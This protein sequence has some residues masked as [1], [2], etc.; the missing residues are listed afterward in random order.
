M[1]P[2]LTQI[3]C[4]HIL[5]T[6][7]LNY[8][9]TPLL[10]CRQVLNSKTC[11]VMTKTTMITQITKTPPRATPSMLPQPRTNMTITASAIPTTSH[12]ISRGLK[13]SQFFPQKI[14]RKG[15]QR[16]SQ[17]FPKIHMVWNAQAS[18]TVLIYC[19]FKN[20][21]VHSAA[22]MEICSWNHNKSFPTNEKIFLIS[23]A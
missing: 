19:M 4:I 23:I 3:A 20:G 6:T 14:W 15:G 10:L 17:T 8:T 21:T 12:Q 7:Y 11:K 2:S 16:P 13:N 18:L 5:R 1:K 22:I 9:L